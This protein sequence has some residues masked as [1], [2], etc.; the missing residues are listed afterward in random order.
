MFF[1]KSPLGVL[2]VQLKNN[3]IYSVSKANSSWKKTEKSL[4]SKSLFMANSDKKT[5]ELIRQLIIFFDNYFSGKH[6]QSQD[7]PLFLRGT[8][9]QRK[10]WQYLR[11][12]PYGQTRA[13]AQVAKVVG[14]AGAARAVGSACAKNPYLILVPCHR[15]VAHKGLGG[16][17]LGLPAKALL[18]NHEK[19]FKDTEK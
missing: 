18:L 4:N 12:I 11:K 9:F 14:S 19:N 10:V 7:L 8:V 1:Y 13:Y 17:A 6:K 5:A 15:V 16:F 3:H 2:E